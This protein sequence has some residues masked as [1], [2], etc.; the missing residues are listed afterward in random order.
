MFGINYFPEQFWFVFL[1]LKGFILCEVG[2]EILYKNNAFNNFPVLVNYSTKYTNI[3]LWTTSLH[4][5]TVSSI[6]RQYS[7]FTYQVYNIIKR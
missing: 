7:V 4:I 2:T 1:G 6:F 5:I 3:T